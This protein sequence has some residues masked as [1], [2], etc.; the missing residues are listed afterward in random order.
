MLN[1]KPVSKIWVYTH[2][3]A[4]MQRVQD[5]VRTGH[6]AYIQ[7]VT[8]A[9]K[10]HATY[11]RLILANPVFDDKLKAFRAREQGLPTGR[12]LMYQSPKS[13]EKIHWF[14][15]IHGKVNQ[16]PTAE[17]WSHAEDSHSRIHFTGYE[18]LRM[19]KEGLKKPVWTWRYVPNR[20][21]DIRDSMVLAI[22]GRRDQD[23]KALID[24]IFGTMGFGGSRE[25][26]KKL[27]TLLK[28]E[29]KQHRP[30]NVMP[31]IP[32]GIGWIRRKADKGVFLTKASLSPP[33]KKERAIDTNKVPGDASSVAALFAKEN[34]NSPP[35]GDG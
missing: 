13:P 30:G 7:G 32:K 22:R 28:S 2:K 15:L 6:Q 31:E 1:R 4:F 23:V 14:L 29:W 8:D 10:M 19:T 18:L 33:A 17:K 24:T 5:Y 12:L 34:N 20:Y 9:Q 25:Q 21:Q 27:V 26:A 3:P 16:L 11:E 35:E